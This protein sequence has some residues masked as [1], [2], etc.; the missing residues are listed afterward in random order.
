MNLNF[1][2]GDILFLIISIA[3][4]A[5]LIY[6]SFLFLKNRNFIKNSIKVKAKVTHSDK[7]EEGKIIKTKSQGFKTIFEFK[8]R[9]ST[10][11]SA[12]T[13]T[14][15]QH[16]VGEDVEILY[17]KDDPKTIRINNWMSLHMLTFATMVISPIS[18]II[19]LM[20]IFSQG[21]LDISLFN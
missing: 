19:V 15:K 20:L 5:N 7:F 18:M 12:S 3:A 1:S 16:Q 2:E 14:P 17:S 8:S 21:K 11:S 9:F 13:I 10:T 6:G 4:L